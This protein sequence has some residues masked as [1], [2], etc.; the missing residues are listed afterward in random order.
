MH[1]EQFLLKANSSHALLAHVTMQAFAVD[2]SDDALGKFDTSMKAYR[3]NLFV[4]EVL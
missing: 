2:A 1:S 3:T 4:S